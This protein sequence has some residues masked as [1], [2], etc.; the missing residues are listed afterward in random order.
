MNSPSV[1]LAHK[2]TVISSTHSFDTCHSDVMLSRQPAL[3]HYRNNTRGHSPLIMNMTKRL[4]QH[5]HT[6]DHIREHPQGYYGFFAGVTRG[7]CTD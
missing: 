7:M 3:L 1:N 5:Q 4:W 2:A 6:H